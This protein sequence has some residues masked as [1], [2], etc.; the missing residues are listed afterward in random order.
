MRHAY[1]HAYDMTYMYAD[2]NGI[3]PVVSM[4]SKK[5]ITSTEQTFYTA[6]SIKFNQFKHCEET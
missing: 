5:I 6:N 1:K 2:S 4:P 3:I